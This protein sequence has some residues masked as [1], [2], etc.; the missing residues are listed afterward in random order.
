MISGS[1]AFSKPGLYIW[2]FSVHIWVCWTGGRVVGRLG[3]SEGIILNYNTSR[4][5]T[6][7]GLSVIV[8]STWS[9]TMCPIKKDKSG[10]N[11]DLDFFCGIPMSNSLSHF[12]FFLIFNIDYRSWW[13]TGRSGVLRFMGSQRVRH[14]WVTELNW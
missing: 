10:W 4:N 9:V 11:P 8:V 3:W 5:R 6:G 13:W 2:K 14:D 1:S 7:K 12:F